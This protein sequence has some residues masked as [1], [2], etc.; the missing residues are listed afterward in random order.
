MESRYM[1]LKKMGDEKNV[2]NGKLLTSGRKNGNIRNRWLCGGS[3][4]RK[5]FMGKETGGNAQTGSG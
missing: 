1:P 4:G 2:K 3:F 5:I